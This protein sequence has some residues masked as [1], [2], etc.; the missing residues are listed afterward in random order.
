[1][2]FVDFIYFFPVFRLN[3]RWILKRNNT[4]EEFMYTDFP[5]YQNHY[6]KYQLQKKVWDQKHFFIQNTANGSKL[7][8][9]RVCICMTYIVCNNNTKKWSSATITWTFFCLLNLFRRRNSIF[10]RNCIKKYKLRSFISCN[11]LQ[12]FICMVQ[13]SI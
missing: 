10:N 5:A 9:D 8:S 7:L 13:C 4:I 3:G 11:G 12:Y 6:I 1:M 2:I